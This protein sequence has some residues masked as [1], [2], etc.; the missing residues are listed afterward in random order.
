MLSILAIIRGIY[1]NLSN[2]SMLKRKTFL[3]ICYLI[4]RTYI[5]FWIV[6]KK[7]GVSW[8]K[9]LRNDSLWRKTQLLKRI[10]GLVL[11]DPSTINM[12]TGPKHYRSLQEITFILLFYHSDK[13]RARK[14][15]F[16][17][18]RKVLNCFLS[19]IAI[20][21]GIYRNQT[22]CFYVKNNKLSDHM[23]LLE[24]T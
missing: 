21:G 14:R 8:L 22:K 15:P 16:R 5:K 24:S 12:L 18:D 20:L 19:I 23:L 2:T 17:S 4:F 13:D 6:W 3:F 7:S 1:P 9:Y 11:E 10:A